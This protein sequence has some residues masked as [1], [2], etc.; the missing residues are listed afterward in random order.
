MAGHGLEPRVDLPDLARA[1]A[2][3][4]RA[5]VVED[6][7]TRHPA[8]HPECLGQSVEQHLVG[9]QFVG[10]DH[11]G[12]AVRQLGMGGLQLEPLAAHRRPVLAPVEL[13]GLAGLKGERYEHPAPGGPLRHLPSR[14][15]AP[16]EGCDPA[17]GSAITQGHQVRVDPPHRPAPLATLA[18]LH[19][20]PFREF[21]GKRVQAAR[22]LGNLEPHLHGVRPQVLA[23]RVP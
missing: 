4:G 7:A 14:L 9:L 8:E 22:T 17:V 11:E 10:P 13:E 16:D 1:D 3:H 19:P 21:V 18:R 5:H 2:I 12:P 6:A 20:Q 23:D 15:P